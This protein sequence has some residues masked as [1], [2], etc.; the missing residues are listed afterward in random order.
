MV[1]ICMKSF[2]SN[3]VNQIKINI[4]MCIHIYI[5]KWYAAK[6]LESY[7]HIHIY[8]SLLG[9]CILPLYD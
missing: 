9:P 4:K 1:L 7:S 6:T 2:F 5:H 3:C 8:T